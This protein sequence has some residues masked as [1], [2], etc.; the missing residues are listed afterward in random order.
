M[1]AV[2]ASINTT[3]VREAIAG[4]GMSMIGQ[5]GLALAVRVR[6]RA[7]GLRIAV[8]LGLLLAAVLRLVLRGLALVGPLLVG[9]HVLAILV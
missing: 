8:L 2:H 6:T 3:A 4:G 7:A 5:Y 9:I 1:T